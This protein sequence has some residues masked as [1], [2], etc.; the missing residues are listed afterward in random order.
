MSITACDIVDTVLQELLNLGMLST[1]DYDAL[2]SGMERQLDAIIGTLRAHH[3]PT[4]APTEVELT[5]FMQRRLDDG[6]ISPEDVAS[7]MARFGLMSPG[8]FVAEMRER[9]ESAQD[10]IDV[11]PPPSARRMKP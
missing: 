4:N 6:G 10:A 8:A 3:A 7:R 11:A 5:N 1:A 9:M 2:P